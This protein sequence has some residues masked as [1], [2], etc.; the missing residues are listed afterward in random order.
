M[1]H[2]HIDMYTYTHY[3]KN[4]HRRGHKGQK[5]TPKG[6]NRTHFKT[7]ISKTN[8]QNALKIYIIKD[9]HLIYISEY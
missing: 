5:R 8:R 7:N 3:K 6:Q 4:S 1:K 9:R 2:L